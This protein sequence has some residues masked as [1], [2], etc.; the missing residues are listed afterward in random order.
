MVGSRGSYVT[1]GLVMVLWTRLS[2]GPQSKT[3]NGRITYN[4][5]DGVGINTRVRETSRGYSHKMV[6]GLLL[7]REVCVVH[8]GGV[9]VAH[10][11]HE[12]SRC[13]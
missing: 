13:C 2:A 7:C 12:G 1:F 4:A 6:I 5:S 3:N 8:G 9:I 11:V 10:M